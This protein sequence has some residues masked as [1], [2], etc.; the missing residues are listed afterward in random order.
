[1]TTANIPTSTSA[2]QVNGHDQG[3]IEPTSPAGAD[4]RE[5]D[6]LANGY[7]A[8]ELGI[9]RQW[10]YALSAFDSVMHSE[11]Q[12]SAS[13]DFAKAVLNVFEER[14][15]GALA[16]ATHAELVI[17]SL[18]AVVEEADRAKAA[19]V[20]V[21]LRD[22]Y[23]RH[24]ADLSEVDSRLTIAQ[25]KMPGEVKATAARLVGSG[26]A[27]QYLAFRTALIA[28]HD[29]AQ[30]RHQRATLDSLFDELSVEW[31]N[32]AVSDPKFDVAIM[33][34]IWERDLSV[35]DFTVEGPDGDK[36][37]EHLA[38][39]RGGIDLWTLKVPRVVAYYQGSDDYPGWVR[40]DKNNHLVN[41]PAEETGNYKQVYE[42]LQSQGHLVAHS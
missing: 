23:V 33:I 39:Q 24:L 2:A 32:Q 28:L 20:S 37:Q 41:L 4:A 19:S 12:K 11:T 9:I 3:V 36:L 31:I 13:P 30:A 29:D 17:G 35:I 40:L 1:M 7:V 27:D 38:A 18:K 16:T 25:E 26:E 8:Y 10:Q 6:E 34:R 15:L 14:I 5:E 42:R 21:A 22:F